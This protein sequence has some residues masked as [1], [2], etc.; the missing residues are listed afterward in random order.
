MG[1]DILLKQK[2]EHD[3][4]MKEA[5]QNHKDPPDIEYTLERESNLPAGCVKYMPKDDTLSIHT[6]GKLAILK[7]DI[8]KSLRDIL[9]KILDD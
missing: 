5:A 8:L 3:E 6:D 4:A 9:N 2:R 7:G 1:R